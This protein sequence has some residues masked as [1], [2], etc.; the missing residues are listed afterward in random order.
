MLTA[1]DVSEIVRA[2]STGLSEV[3]VSVDMG[4]TPVV[5]RISGSVVYLGEDASVGIDELAE[6]EEGYAYKLVSGRLVRLDMYDSGR[7]YKLKPTAPRSA[8]TLE[9]SGIQMHR[10]TGVDPWTDTLL[11]VS[12]LGSLRGAEVLDVCA[13]LGYTAIAEVARGAERVVTV[14]VDPN[15][16]KMAQHNPWSRKLEDPR[17][18][19]VLED[20]TEYVEELE[21]E[22][23]DA[24][25]HDPP[26]I[27][28]AG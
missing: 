28:I 13:G 12:S 25:L 21:S 22:R 27:S 4:L 9:I 11:K 20:A 19:V 16:L 5:A 17:V 8:P 15:V 14:E 18:E 26:R 24:V 10:T 2:R 23:F 3:V 6:V 7:Y 1:W